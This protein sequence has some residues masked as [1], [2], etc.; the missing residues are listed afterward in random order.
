M[1]LPLEKGDGCRGGPWT[2]HVGPAAAYTGL[3]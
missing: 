3:G 1:E 2:A